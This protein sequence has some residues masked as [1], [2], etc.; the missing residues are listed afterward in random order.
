MRANFELF[1][2]ELP[3]LPYLPEIIIL[4]EIWI[5]TMETKFYESS[6]Y[7]QHTKPS[8]TYRAGRIAVFIH[9]SITVIETI[10]VNFKTADERMHRRHHHPSTDFIKEL[11]QSL[12]KPI[13]KICKNVYSS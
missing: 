12:G 5:N 13:V 6:N 2:I 10:P 4:S 11:K 7:L 9:N 8:K 1:L 3:V